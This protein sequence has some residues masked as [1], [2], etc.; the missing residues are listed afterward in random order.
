M[1]IR[2]RLPPKHQL[3]SI[4]L[5]VQE[6]SLVLWF[7]HGPPRKL[8]QLS[9]NQPVPPSPAELVHECCS[10]LPTIVPVTVPVRPSA[11]RRTPD[12]LAPVWVN[13]T[14]ASPNPLPVV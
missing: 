12:T 9:S 1:R 14:S 8:F 13:T 7:R 11:Y 6:P 5:R 2:L 4:R 3:P 10:L